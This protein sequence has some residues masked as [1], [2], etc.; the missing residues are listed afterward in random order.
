MLRLTEK[1]KELWATKPLRGSEFTFVLERLTSDENTDENKA[2]QIHDMGVEKDSYNINYPVAGEWGYSFTHL[3]GRIDGS[4]RAIQA[5]Y[6]TPPGNRQEALDIM[7]EF[8]MRQYIKDAPHPWVSMNGHYPFHH[9]AGEFGF[10]ILNSEVGENINGAQWHIALNRGAAKQY[11]TPWS[12]DFSAWNSGTITDYRPEKLWGECSS[13]TG[14]HSL[15]YME[16]IFHMTYMAGAGE[17]VAEAGSLISCLGEKDE[18]GVL[19]PS[20]YGLKC[21]DFHKYVKQNPDRGVC[22][23]PIAIVLD[24]YHGA[25]SG[26]E[27]RKAFDYF[28]YNKGDEMTWS[29]VDMLWPECWSGGWF[30]VAANNETRGFVNSPYGDYYDVFLQNVSAELLQTYPCVIL[31]GDVHFS[32]DD[33]HKFT[34][35]VEKGGK[36]FLNRAYLSAFSEF[37]KLDGNETVTEC[38]YGKGSVVIYG[39]DYD[40]SGL[41]IALLTTLRELI[42]FRVNQKLLQMVNVCEDR[43]LLTLINNSGVSKARD[44]E[45][46][47]DPDEVRFLRVTYTGEEKIDSMKNLKS[48][49]VYPAVDNTVEFYMKSGEI[50]ILEVKTV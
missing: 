34:N 12:I 13:L 45:E 38:A 6:Q 20:P 29:L 48:K 24:Y 50:A 10:D 7:K 16:R 28:P 18:E 1:Q 4:G 37:S 22:Y 40:L 5:G 41:D 23:T 31:S 11:Q 49:E 35:Y 46:A 43:L 9:Y 2:I 30:G 27:E 32:E 21:R 25:Y 8:L 42:P 14:G 17:M 15:S 3:N 36:L 19:K 47:I 39:Y 44:C 33:V 26:L